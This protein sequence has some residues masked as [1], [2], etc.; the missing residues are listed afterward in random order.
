MFFSRL[1]LVVFK[2]TGGRAWNPPGGLRP[3]S[4]PQKRNRRKNVELMLKNLS[5]LKLAEAHQPHVPIR[6]YK[7]LNHSRLIWMKKKIEETRRALGWDLQQRPLAVQA[8]ALA[9]QRQEQQGLGPG[10]PVP[11][12]LPPVARAAMQQQHANEQ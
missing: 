1:L 7:S 10:R 9:Q 8:Q 2:T 3:L 4:V 11:S 12:L 5:I 6:L